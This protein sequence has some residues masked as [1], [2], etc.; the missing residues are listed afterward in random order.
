[1]PLGRESALAHPAQFVGESLTSAWPILTD[2]LSG[3]QP[4]R[5]SLTFLAPERTNGCRV[6]RGRRI[7]GDERL[8]RMPA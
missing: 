7:N 5:P 6:V 3:Q 2:G 4:L 8:G 1:M